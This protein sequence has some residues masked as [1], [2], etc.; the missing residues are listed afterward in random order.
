MG[1]LRRGNSSRPS[2]RDRPRP[3]LR[4]QRYSSTPVFV[5]GGAVSRAPW[6][7]RRAKAAGPRY[8]NL[9]M[10]RRRRRA[11]CSASSASP[12][13]SAASASGSS[14]VASTSFPSARVRST[15]RTQCSAYCL[16][17]RSGRHLASEDWMPTIRT[18]HQPDC[19]LNG[20]DWRADW[21]AGGSGR[22]KL[23][24]RTKSRRARAGKTVTCTLAGA[25][26]RK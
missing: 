24:A 1:T 9:R 5:G 20:E 15:S 14:L 3:R 18:R 17:V 7:T 19:G 21:R 11:S 25:H 8:M 26:R 6:V 4:I 23:A 22:A 13:R 12:Q 10:R 2:R 16:K